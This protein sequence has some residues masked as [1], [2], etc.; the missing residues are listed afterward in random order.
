MYILRFLKRGR[1]AGMDLEIKHPSSGL[2]APFGI[3]VD[4][5]AEPPLDVVR[6]QRQ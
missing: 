3:V 2:T 6:V 5:P 1:H 4:C